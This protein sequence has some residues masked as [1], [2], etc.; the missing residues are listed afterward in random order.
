MAA[1]IVDFYYRYHAGQGFAGAPL[2]DPCAVAVLIAPEIFSKRD[3][4]IDI[5][6]RGAH[7][8]GMTLADLRIWTDAAPNA[9]VCLDIDRAAFIRLLINACKSYH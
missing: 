3:M 2:H 4:H 5:E 7:T 1:G 9:T 6:T 8:T